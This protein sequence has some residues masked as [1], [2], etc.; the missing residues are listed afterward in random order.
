MTLGY[1]QKHDT[2]LLNYQIFNGMSNESPSN[3][4]NYMSR[5]QHWWFASH[6]I[7]LFHY[8]FKDLIFNGWINMHA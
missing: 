5:N 6:A 8:K 1:H 3:E 2:Q 7:N 4:E